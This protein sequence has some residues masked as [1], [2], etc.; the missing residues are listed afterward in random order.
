[1]HLPKVAGKYFNSPFFKMAANA[2][3]QT[4]KRDISWTRLAKGAYKV[5]FPTNLGTTDLTEQ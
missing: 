1:M 5:S 4:I 2:I 3:L